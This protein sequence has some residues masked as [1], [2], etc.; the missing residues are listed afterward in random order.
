MEID[1][2]LILDKIVKLI[3]CGCSFEEFVFNAN[4]D[5]WHLEINNL[6]L[7]YSVSE[8]E[9]YI[10][11]DNLVKNSIKLDF[12]EAVRIWTKVSSHRQWY[13]LNT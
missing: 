5:R 7:E 2:K 8:S 12:G 11:I 1:G 4:E 9:L 10:T 3:D 6:K 13:F